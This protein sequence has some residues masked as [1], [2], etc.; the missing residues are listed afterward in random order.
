MDTL[1]GD[2]MKETSTPRTHPEQ[3][4][5]VATSM[6]IK[7]WLNPEDNILV[8]GVSWIARITRQGDITSD[9]N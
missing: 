9:I 8:G 4:V 7:N 1:D 2:D 3:K 6:K 5:A